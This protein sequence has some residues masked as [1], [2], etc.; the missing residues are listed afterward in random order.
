MYD[1]LLPSF[2]AGIVGY[3]VSASLGITYFALPIT[4]LPPF[5]AVFFLELCLAGVFFGA[6]SFMLIE[7]LKRSDALSKKIK[8]SK[9]LKALLGGSMIVIL[10]L[11]FGDR[12]LGLGLNTIESALL[13]EHI[14]AAAFALKSVFTAL[15][16]S[17]G[18]SGGIVTPIFFV[19]STAGNLFGNIMGLDPQLFAAIGMVETY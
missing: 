17:F 9:P 19:G 10:A 13:G 1:V 3:Q 16:L 7:L 2:V 5:T 14:P 18:G 11:I 6:C 15:T 12:Y 8:L 4:T